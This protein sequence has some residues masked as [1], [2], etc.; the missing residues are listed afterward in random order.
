MEKKSFFDFFPVPR[1]LEMPAVG[2]ALSDDAIRFVEYEE[3]FKGL[4]LKR[5]GETLLPPSVIRAGHIEDPKTL[6]TFLKETKKKIGVDFVYTALPEEKVYLFQTEIPVVRPK[7][8][9]ETVEFKIEENVPLSLSEIVFDYHVIYPQFAE[10][11]LD[12]VVC[13]LPAKLA[14]MYTDILKAADLTPLSLEIESQAIARA[15]VK[16]KDPRPTLVIN[17]SRFKTGFHIINRGVVHF[18][19]TITR[20]TQSLFGQFPQQV[21]Q[22]LSGDEKG[23]AYLPPPFQ[24]QTAILFKDTANKF[25]S[26][27]QTYR[28]NKENKAIERIIVCG[29]R[30]FEK[31][32]VN[33]LGSQ[34]GIATEVGNVWANAF[35]FDNYIP[36]LP[37]NQSLNYAAAAGLALSS[38]R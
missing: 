4:R 17:L 18:S 34:T 12:V 6:I 3:S 30:S 38:I 16:N 14:S 15:V 7:E 19:S 11:H 20:G 23:K 10:D 8:V 21:R 28:G 2:L 29:E 32:F 25:L 26:Y 5:F 35:S 27:W 33:Y 1:F 22:A 13:V 31:D 36:P 9:R 37:F 24:E